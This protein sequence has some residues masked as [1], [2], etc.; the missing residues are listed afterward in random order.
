MT[1]AVPVDLF[2]GF[3]DEGKRMFDFEHEHLLE[4]YGISFDNFGYPQLIT[5]YMAEGDLHAYLACQTTVI[6]QIF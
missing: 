3:L 2:R 5:P 6:I 1:F 4:I